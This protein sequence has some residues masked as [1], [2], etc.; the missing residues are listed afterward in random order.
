MQEIHSS[1][2]ANS[3]GQRIL[4]TVALI[5]ALAAVCAAWPQAAPSDQGAFMRLVGTAKSISP[6]SLTVAGD[7]GTEARVTLD[8]TTR[9]L[10]VEPGQ[11]DLTSATP[12]QL[13]DIQP[14]DR[15]LVRA[16][17]SDD[18]KT[19]IATSVVVMK[20]SDIAERRERERSDWQHRGVG[21]LVKSVDPTT[22]VITITSTGLMGTQN[23]AVQV[24]KGTV[25]R[26]Y[27]P[28]SVRFD[29]AKPGTLDQI[30]PG[31][32]LRA[33]GTRSAE[34]TQLAAEEIV[35]GSFLNLAGRIASIDKDKNTVELVDLATKKPVSVVIAADSQL[36]KLPPMLAQRIAMRLKGTA[37]EAH[38]PGAERRA[39]SVN[40]PDSHAPANGT[41]QQGDFQQ[42]L[43]RMPP[44]TLADLQKGEAVMIVATEPTQNSGP[45]AI[46]LLSGVEPILTAAP[47][48]SAAT[49]LSPWNLAAGEPA[50]Q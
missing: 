16:R 14:G 4:A 38:A 43:N 2:K 35:S 41:R 1:P 34:G 10:R 50:S 9:L 23:I 42:M 8:A 3:A 49:V 30:K 7:A 26:R 12:I 25:I 40:G 28:G 33:R 36:K 11:K 46:T 19:L 45:R 29:D 47:E 37:P 6:N 48:G 17:P 5:L 32:Q 27:A 22:G 13:Q 24:S 39:A 18:A 15:I 44:L 21:G 20:Q 31:D